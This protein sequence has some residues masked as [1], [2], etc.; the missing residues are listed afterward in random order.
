MDIKKG[1]YIYFV[2][3]KKRVGPPMKYLGDNL[4]L[5]FD[6][7][8]TH[9][10]QKKAAR[11]ICVSFADASFLPLCPALRVLWWIITNNR[12]SYMYKWGLT[13]GYPPVESYLVTRYYS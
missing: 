10:M 6:D 9:G 7:K 3:P 12:K 5:T 4:Y 13:V 8:V 1:D 2:Y 11:K